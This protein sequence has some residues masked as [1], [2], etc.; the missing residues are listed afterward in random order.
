VP[1]CY[2]HLVTPP[3]FNFDDPDYLAD[4]AYTKDKGGK[5]NSTRTAAESISATFS[6]I[7]PGPRFQTAMLTQIYPQTVTYAGY[8]IR[9]FTRLH[10]LITMAQAD[11]F[12]CVLTQKA[13]YQFWRPWQTITRAAEWAHSYP[14]L[15][16]LADPT[17]EPFLTTP[18][19][20]EYPAGHPTASSCLA[21]TLRRVLGWSG[22]FPGGSITTVANP[23]V[24]ETFLTV[25]EIEEKMVNARVFGGMHYRNSG[26]V[27]VQLGH[28]LVDWT[29][30]H[31]LQS[32][33][34][35]DTFDD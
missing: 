8:D 23:A 30:D 35:D 20:P 18:P 4:V 27:G 32:V 10:A 9:D 25:G 22:K 3:Y 33:Y 26:R 34:D 5:F 29:V 31:Y 17:W 19:N 1:T 14:K 28:N 7:L 11:S 15:A 6:V 2:H 12:T 16:Q 21:H 13:H 24:N